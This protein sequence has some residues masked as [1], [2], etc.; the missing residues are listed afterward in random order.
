MLASC[1]LLA[2]DILFRRLCSLPTN[3][4]S[5]AKLSLL[6]IEEMLV[7]CLQLNITFIINS[8]GRRLR[9]KEL[10]F[11]TELVRPLVPISKLFS[12]YRSKESLLIT[13]ASW[14]LF[15]LLKHGILDVIEELSL[16]VSFDAVADSRVD[17]S[18]FLEVLLSKSVLLFLD[19]RVYLHLG[20]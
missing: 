20:I 18:L 15:K 7:R 12:F 1:K 8:V 4:V 9:L 13:M 19:G 6:G 14:R 11:R 5:F 3:I 16:R 17:S 2:I 10:S